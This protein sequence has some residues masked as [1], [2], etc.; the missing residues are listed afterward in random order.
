MGK[1][2]DAALADGQGQARHRDDEPSANR[3]WV[4]V[5]FV[6]AAFILGLV[7]PYVS[8]AGL[9]FVGYGGH[10]TFAFGFLSF[11]FLIAATS[12]VVLVMRR[13]RRTAES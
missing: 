12:A 11:A 6:I 13:A 1:W 8:I 5:K 2:L 9:M 10:P 3:P 7:L 4:I